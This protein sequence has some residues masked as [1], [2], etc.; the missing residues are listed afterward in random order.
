MDAFFGK[1][2]FK[3][4]FLTM[5]SAE[6][7]GLFNTAV[8]V[9][10]FHLQDPLTRVRFQDDVRNFARSQMNIIRTSTDDKQC[11]QCIQAIRQERDNLLIQD[12]MLRTGEAVLTASVR[13][14]QENEK[15]IGY[16]I[17]G[18]GVVLGG[19]QV[20]A[21]IGVIATSVPTGNVIGVVAGASLILNGIS[22]A[23]ESIQK[24]YGVQRPVNFMKDAYKNTAEFLGFDKK[25]GLL[26]YQ[27]VDLTTSYYGVFKLTVKPD[28]WRLF[29]YVTPDFQ[30]KINSMSKPALAIKGFGAGWKGVQI[31]NNLANLQNQQQ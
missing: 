17:D 14:Y 29:H 31:G 26:A 16:I 28:A 11:Q 6:A 23:T 15:V 8:S 25:V 30:R 24:L 9:S 18:I 7:S 20:I 12:R 2:R 19:V 4:Y 27:L 3:S 1:D 5:A 21:G 13:F 22:S 10:A